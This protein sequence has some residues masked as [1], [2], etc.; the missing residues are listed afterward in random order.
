[1]NVASPGRASSGWLGQCV[2]LTGVETATYLRDRAAIFWTFIYPI[3][4]LI[5]MMTLFG[6]AAEERTFRMALDLEGHGPAAEQV[7]N[8][9]RSNFEMIDGVDFDL[10][11]VAPDQATPAGR[12]RL[13]VPPAAANGVQSL[14][15]GLKGTPDASSGSML[16]IVAQ[17]ASQLDLELAGAPSRVR[18]RYDLS[19]GESPPM[20]SS[21]Y[22][23][24]GLGVLTIVSTALFGF[25][26][27]LIDLRARGGL[28]LFQFMPVHRTAFLTAF[29]LC[30]VIILF[31]FVTL[32]IAA[33]LAL[34]GGLSEVSGEG[35][36]TMLLLNILGTISFLTAGLAIA[37]L[38][39]SNTL[40]SA[41][42]NI[43]NLPIVF[44]SD[45][46]IPISSMP[47]PVQAVS[48]VTPVYLLVDAMRG[49]AAGTRTLADCGP[50]IIALV[51][52]FAASAAIVATTF[53]WRLKR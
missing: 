11:R 31:V 39:T 17:T 47:E 16:S 25:S 15:V 43:I 30:R 46:F 53:R 3:A 9:I 37:G 52:L 23:V 34:F 51:I 28:K 13:I 21:V 6:G 41:L 18:L 44:L 27:P 33:G 22:Y 45:L 4:L 12:V 38:V 7:A 2:R 29:G 24:V 19:A 14:T 40:G 10:R 42:I 50:A 36:T 48:R 8:R 20:S 5:L 1:M 49:A 35:W 26:A 32:F